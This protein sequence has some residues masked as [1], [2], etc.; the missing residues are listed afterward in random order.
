M[1]PGRLR[2]VR[3]TKAAIVFQGALHSLNPVQQVGS[4]IAEAIAVHATA[5]AGRARP[6]KVGEL[7]ERVGDPDGAGRRVPAPAVGRP[8]PAGA[9]RP[10]P[11]VRAGPADRR[12]ADHRPRR[13]G[14]GPGARPA[15]RAP[16][17]RRHGDA[18]HHPRP[19]RA[20]VDV[21]A[22]GGDVR[23][24]DR[25]GGARPRRAHQP[26]HPYTRALA[27]AFP[28]IGDAAS[29]MRPSGL[30]GDPPDPVE[31]PSGCPFHPRC[32]VAVDVVRDRPDRA[33]AGRRRA[34]GRMRPRGA[35]DVD[36]WLTTPPRPRCSRSATST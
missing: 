7:L 27:A 24:A 15:R 1:K 34:P 11:G 17:R 12:R 4:Q 31:L 20:H 35:E 3:W 36:R 8:A 22:G 2:A 13:D 25:R 18:V 28:T 21:R 6:A 32:D 16:A 26:E 29:R 23:R 5:R 10:R 14:P 19:V 30:R 33:P 9:D